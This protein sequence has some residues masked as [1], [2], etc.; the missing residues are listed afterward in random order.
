MFEGSI[1]DCHP[2][3]NKFSVIVTS[4]GNTF[5]GKIQDQGKTMVGTFSMKNGST[6]S[7]TFTQFSLDGLY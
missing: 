6:I 3:E 1:I 7:G 2:E 4:Y 5:R